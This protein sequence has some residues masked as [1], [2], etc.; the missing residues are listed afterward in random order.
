MLLSFTSCTSKSNKSNSLKLTLKGIGTY[1]FS[2]SSEKKRVVKALKAGL[3]IG[4]A[5]SCWDPAVYEELVTKKKVKTKGGENRNR[6]R[7]QAQSLKED[8]TLGDLLE[9]LETLGDYDLQ[10]EFIKKIPSYKTRWILRWYLSE[11][12]NR[13]VSERELLSDWEAFQ[14]VKKYL[15]RSNNKFIA[16]NKH[17][18]RLYFTGH[19]DPHN[20]AR[21]LVKVGVR[22]AW[23]AEATLELLRESVSNFIWD[24]DLC[25]KV[26]LVACCRDIR[27]LSIKLKV[28]IVR[29]HFQFPKNRLG[30][31]SELKKA[32]RVWVVAPILP[33]KLALKVFKFQ[34]T[35][36]FRLAQA[37]YNP[38]Q[39]E[40]EFWIEF[41]RLLKL[42]NRREK[43]TKLY[44]AGYKKVAINL[45]HQG[46]NQL[47]EKALIDWYDDECGLDFEFLNLKVK[48]LNAILENFNGK[49]SWNCIKMAYTFGNN[50]KAWLSKNKKLNRSFHDATYFL[51]T[52]GG[53]KGLDSF[54]LKYANKP[55]YELEL[56]C[57][58]W[59]RLTSKDLQLNF[60]D[61][62]AKLRTN[63]YVKI[64]VEEFAIECAKHGVT[65]RNYATFEN[66]YL[67]AQTEKDFHPEVEIQKEGY[68]G[69]FLPRADVRGVFL[70][71]YTNCCQH[72][73]GMGKDCAWYGLEKANSGFFV[74]TDK[75][76]EIIAQSWV[77]ST[78]K[79]ICFD[80]VEAKGLGERDSLVGS[81]YKEAANVLKESYRWVTMGLT[82]GDLKC[83]FEIS[84]ENQTQILEVPNDFSGYTDAK[85]QVVL[86]C[87]PKVRILSNTNDVRVVGVTQN[88][89]EGLELV[90]Q[91]VYPEG[92]QF[93]GS[94]E[95]DFALKLLKGSQIIGYCTIETANR[96][97]S[98]IAV[99]EEYRKYSNL[100][101]NRVLNYCRTLGGSW[102]ADCRISTSYRLLKLFERRGRLNL[103]ED[104][105]S[106]Q[107]MDN[108]SMRRVRFEVI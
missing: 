42:Q 40:E 99:I 85:S 100:L 95:T 6:K 53:V 23:Q 33:K 55:T 11:Y 54:L 76:D 38:Y 103:I 56:V 87:N 88:D 39:T 91:T 71:Q 1:T 81:I 30:S 62:I 51:P 10:M 47:S 20:F 46:V 16:I 2:T 4:E 25:T 3:E 13:A 45:V 52:I 75:E 67:V 29:A 74:V 107:S 97:I 98:D 26:C 82:L 96:Y 59:D 5:L 101:I 18:T 50:W 64:N 106:S 34:D 105:E 73:A 36:K 57:Q 27:K 66:R 35:M 12:G 77:W 49:F 92:W 21:D 94:E 14:D 31:Y 8:L 58:S 93:A 63:V 86:A 83:V 65:D 22:F 78:P 90:A 70:G 69:K 41:N 61:L 28:A 89:L 68:T 102:E 9:K 80:N 79:G 32:A 43:A 19:S 60:T 48:A 24:Y 44:Q 72:P 84:M 37:S 108:H 15:L 7:L 104:C 17:G